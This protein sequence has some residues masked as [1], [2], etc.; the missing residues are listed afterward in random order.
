MK[1]T[2][3]PCTIRSLD[4]KVHVCGLYADV[5][6]TLTIKNPN[7]RD[8]SA[9]IAIPMPDRAVV[10]GYALD[11][12]GQMID[13]VVVPKEKAR[14]VFETEQRIGADPGLVESVKGNVY[15]TR[16]YPIPGRRRARSS[17]AMSRRC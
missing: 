9:N 6:E 2:D 13:G 17:C 14:V 8:L 11:I 15:R 10:C 4:L 5:T 16:V 3:K 1:S 7:A 12:D